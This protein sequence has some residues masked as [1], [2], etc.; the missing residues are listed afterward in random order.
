MSKGKSLIPKMLLTP[1]RSNKPPCVF[2]HRWFV[3]L[4][5]LP[6]HLLILLVLHHHIHIN[7]TYLYFHDNT[8]TLA[9]YDSLGRH[10]NFFLRIPTKQFQIQIVDVDALIDYRE[11]L[12]HP[13][14]GFR[15]NLFP[16]TSVIMDDMRHPFK[17]LLNPSRSLFHSAI[18]C[19]R[20]TQR[21]PRKGRNFD[22]TS[23]QCRSY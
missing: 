15:S 8:S 21:P 19:P 20:E 9:L 6:R 14:L 3:L 18:S 10:R 2:P 23:P 7:M 1:N 13:T 17:T 4:G 22:H 12:R 5:H 11:M 16:L